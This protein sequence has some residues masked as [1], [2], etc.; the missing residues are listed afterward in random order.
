VGEDLL[1]VG[2]VSTLEIS[3]P[4]EI[5]TATLRIALARDRP[6]ADVVAADCQA[7]GFTGIGSQPL[8]PLGRQLRVTKLSVVGI[9]GV[10]RVDR[11]DGAFE[12]PLV[13]PTSVRR[14]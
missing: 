3:T 1:E 5:A 8:N 13:H 12:P 10:G 4:L 11:G 6:S 2:R 7:Q 14:D 9:R